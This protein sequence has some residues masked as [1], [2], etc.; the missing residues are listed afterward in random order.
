M[1]MKQARWLI[2]S[3]IVLALLSIVWSHRPG[4]LQLETPVGGALLP[5]SVPTD[6]SLKAPGCDLSLGELGS[7]TVQAPARIVPLHKFVLTVTPSA[8]LAKNLGAVSVDFQMIGMDMGVNNYPLQRAADGAYSQ[9]II[10]PVC[11]TTR[12]D[13][14]ALLMLHTPR[15]AYLAKIPFSVDPR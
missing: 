14:V 15:G 12:T 1:S 3:F 9:T 13:W 7:V 6:C 8:E 11:T 5:V 10:L 4:T 2:G